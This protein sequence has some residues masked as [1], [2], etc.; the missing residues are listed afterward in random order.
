[1]SQTHECQ[2]PGC[3]TIIRIRFTMCHQHWHMVPRALQ[4]RVNDEYHAWEEIGRGHITVGY[5]KAVEAA[6]E[7]VTEKT[8]RDDDPVS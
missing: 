6:I 3:D 8:R 4:D 1:M 5:R 2:I 7:I